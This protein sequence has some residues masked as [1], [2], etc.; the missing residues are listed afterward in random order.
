AVVALHRPRVVAVVALE[1]RD[2]LRG[3]AEHAARLRDA[4]LDVLRELRG[5]D[6]VGA[7]R[8]A[9][10]VDRPRRLAAA[11]V[12]RPR[13]LVR[14]AVREIDLLARG[15]RDEADVAAAAGLVADDRRVA[16]A[17]RDLLAGAAGARLL[18]AAV[19]GGARRPPL[20]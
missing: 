14:A 6:V 1:L 9:A 15:R 10:D 12:G 5:D 13:D 18:R 8:V 4:L 2:V 3:H 11:A 16:V 20:R 19:A 7:E 17:R